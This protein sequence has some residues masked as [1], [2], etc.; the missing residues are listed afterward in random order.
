MGLW[1]F[2]QARPASTLQTAGGPVLQASRFDS[3]RMSSL[4]SPRD[5]VH[6]HSPRMAAPSAPPPRDARR[7]VLLFARGDRAEA[8]CKG[9]GAKGAA[10][11]AAL[12]ARVARSVEALADVDLVV[13]GAP[14]ALQPA[15]VLPQRG[16]A[17]GARVEAAFRDARAAGY[18]HILMVGID[19][20]GLRPAHLQ[21]AFTLLNDRGCVLGPAADGGAYLIGVGPGGQPAFDGGVRWLGSHVFGDL[22]RACPDAARL[23]EL[24]DVD[25]LADLRRLACDDAVLGRLLA[26]IVATPKLWPRALSGARSGPLWRAAPIRGPPG[27]TAL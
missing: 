3:Y 25:T 5:H 21:D 16:L 19:A 9:L 20:P 1:V 11:F 8:R 22:L 24:R 13:A 14:G 27:P 6:P 23:P 4:A 12:R 18:T 26:A 15:L 10:V 17:F 7:C 2:R